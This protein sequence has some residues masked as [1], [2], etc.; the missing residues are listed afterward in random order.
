MEQVP[1]S[2]NASNKQ[3]PLPAACVSTF[4]FAKKALSS[5]S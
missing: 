5:S 2:D 3:S 1:E 4:F